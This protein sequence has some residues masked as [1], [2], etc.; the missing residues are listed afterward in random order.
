MTKGLFVVITIFSGLIAMWIYSGE[1]RKIIQPK[2]LLVYALSLVLTLPEL[3]C[4]YFT[5]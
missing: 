3:V 1:L 2:W 5:I 4:L